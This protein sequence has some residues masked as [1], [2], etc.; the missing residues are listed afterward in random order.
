MVHFVSLADDHRGRGGLKAFAYGPQGGARLARDHVGQLA[1]GVGHVLV[2]LGVAFHQH[3]VDDSQNRFLVQGQGHGAHGVS[4]DSDKAG[5]VSHGR[6]G[7][8]EVWFSR[9]GLH[10]GHGGQDLERGVQEGIDEIHI[11]AESHQALRGPWDRKKVRGFTGM[12]VFVRGCGMVVPRCI[13]EDVAGIN[14]KRDDFLQFGLFYRIFPDGPRERAPAVEAGQMEATADE[15]MDFGQELGSAFMPSK[16]EPKA[17]RARGFFATGLKPVYPEEVVCPK[18][19]S[20][21]AA[22]TRGDGSRRS[23]KYYHGYHGGMDIPVPEGTP[24][25]AVAWGE[26]VHKSVGQ[27]GIGGIAVV[28]RHAPEAPEGAVVEVVM[29]PGKACRSRRPFP[30]APR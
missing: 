6:V 2:D 9:P 28:L 5:D 18:A 16:A 23:S 24:I 29:G 1:H 26:V 19:D 10:L 21:F 14:P 3:V 12:F 4:G 15:D 22:R 8:V 30:G 11:E 13:R 27:G 20:A 17:M 7:F 25:R